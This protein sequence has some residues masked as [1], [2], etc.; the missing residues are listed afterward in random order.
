MPNG[1]IFHKSA[2]TG[3][4]SNWGES[5]REREPYTCFVWLVQ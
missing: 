3:K 2:V 5:D 4:V 1:I